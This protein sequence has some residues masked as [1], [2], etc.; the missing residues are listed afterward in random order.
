MC[1]R[2]LVLDGLVIFR[3]GA[4]AIAHPCLQLFIQILCLKVSGTHSLTLPK[5]AH[6][7]AV[8]SRSLLAEWQ[9]N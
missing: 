3:A 2:F 4:V 5:D 9:S 1:L 8:V 6:H 7:P